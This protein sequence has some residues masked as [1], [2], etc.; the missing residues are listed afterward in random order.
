[1]AWSLIGSPLKGQAAMHPFQNHILSWKYF[2]C[3]VTVDVFETDRKRMVTHA[4]CV[5]SY[6]LAFH[7]G[8]S[9]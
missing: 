2:V 9:N 6:Q 1:M 3:A 4:Q 7:P 8:I 5:Q